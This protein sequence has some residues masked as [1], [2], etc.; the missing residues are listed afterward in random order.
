MT[1]V[2]LTVLF[3]AWL[4]LGTVFGISLL[5]IWVQDRWRTRHVITEATRYIRGADR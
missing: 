3:V 2:A 1:Q 5:V 4:V